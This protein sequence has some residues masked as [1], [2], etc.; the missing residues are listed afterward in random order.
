M[1]LVSIIIPTYNSEASI[2]VCLT[3]ITSQNFKNFEVIIVDGLSNDETVSLALQYRDRLPELRCISEKDRGI[4][5]AMNKGI[6][7][8]KGKWILFLGSDD[9]L[10]SD[11][12][13]N[14]IQKELPGFDVLYGNVVSSRFNGIYDGEFTKEKI[15]QQNI[16]HQAILFNKS[17]FKTIG[18]FNTKYK[19]HADWDHNLRWFLSP[20]VKHKYIPTIISNYADGGY[21]STVDEVFFKDIKF[22][23]YCVL[24][25]RTIRLKDKLAII[26][27]EYRLAID[28]KRRRDAVM[29]LRQIPYFLL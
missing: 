8:A 25:K 26:K 11:N 6:R 19:S 20:R 13:L 22:W 3:S 17:V 2:A 28:Q 12:T 21:S 1:P 27:K 15:Y 14:E 29:I 4:Y 24:T 16:C 7:W 5:D 9:F 23:K 10:Y 18:L